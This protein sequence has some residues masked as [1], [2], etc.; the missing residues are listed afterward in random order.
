LLGKRFGEKGE[1]SV[2]KSEAMSVLRAVVATNVETG[3]PYKALSEAFAADDLENHPEDVDDEGA[4]ES[5]LDAIRIPCM[6]A[7][8]LPQSVTYVH[9]RFAQGWWVIYVCTGGDDDDTSDDLKTEMW[10]LFS[11]R[12]AM[13]RISKWVKAS[14]HER[15]PP[16]TVL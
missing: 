3:K 9:L 2:K 14:P 13:E 7:P 10:G 1:A 12:A 11:R 4:R 8:S 5:Q 15:V 16:F 6:T